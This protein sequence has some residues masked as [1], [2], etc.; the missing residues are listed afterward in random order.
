MIRAANLL[1]QYNSFKALTYTLIKSILSF[2]GCEC[3]SWARDK[4]SVSQQRQCDNVIEPQGP[5]KILKIF[6]SRD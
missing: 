5:E 4:F 6:R 2:Y 3:Q 1:A